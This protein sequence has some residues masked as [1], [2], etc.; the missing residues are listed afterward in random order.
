MNAVLKNYCG[1]HNFHNYTVKVKPT[2]AQAKRYILSLIVPNR[3]R[4]TAASFDVK[5][6]GS[7]S[8]CI[9]FVNIGTMLAVVRA[10][11]RRMIRSLRSSRTDTCRRRWR[12]A[13]I[14]SV[15]GIFG[16]YN[17]RLGSVH[18]AFTLDKYAEKSENFKRTHVYTHIA[19]QASKAR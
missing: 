2:D 11:S 19:N 10:N 3:S 13:R 18:D 15:Q 17:D 9:R 6:S 4:R 16:A 14:V 7:H 8:C 1:A 5:S 12:R